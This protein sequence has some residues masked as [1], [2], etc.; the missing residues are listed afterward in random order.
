VAVRPL[1]EPELAVGALTLE[2]HPTPGH[3]AGHC[4]F[5]FR[6]AGTRALFSG[7]LVFARGRVAVLGTPDTDLGALAA[8]LRAVAALAPDALLP[9]H[10]APVLRDAH[11][12]LLS[13]VGHLERGE[14][15]PGLLP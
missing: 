2:V 6:D 3:A 14:L 7:D 8:S 9:G 1:D 13:A 12:H 4:C 11:A 15:P 5:S 10:G